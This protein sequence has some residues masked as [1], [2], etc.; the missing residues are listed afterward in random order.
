VYRADHV[1]SFLRPP[2]LLATPAK[3]PRRREIEDGA[4]LR[5]LEL[6]RE[7]GVD[8]YTDGEYRRTWFAGAWGDSVRG[9]VDAPPQPFIARGWRG[10]SSDLAMQS[11]AEVATH[12]AVGEKVRQVRRFAQDECEFLRE[13]APG[14][15][16]IT[17]TSA[18]TN[19]VYWYQP[20][21][22]AAVYPTRRELVDEMAGLLRDEVAALVDEGAAYIQL[23]SLLYSIELAD[24]ENRRRL[25]D[26]GIDPDE[27]LDEAIAGDNASLAPAMA[28]EGVT[29]GLHMCRG[30]NRS[31]WT[32]EGGYEAIAERAFSELEVDRLLLEYDTARAG[33][34]E[35]LRF[36]PDD[37]A[38]VLGLI[39]TK[40]PE[41]ESRDELLRRIEEAGRY[42]PVERLALSP[43]CGFASTAKGNLLGWDDQRRKLELVVETARE[44]WS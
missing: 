8:V 39:S 5:V 33:G 21:I 9:L 16:K 27:V 25:V 12:G 14:P 2:E 37:K 18:V 32:A 30:N 11:L 43:Q 3:D 4:I 38:V 26:C 19:A 24:P 29:V 13:H 44:I 42:V 17:L 6:Q 7:V 41:L 34:F 22:S 20:A 40:T 35:P 31:A 28:A 23:D 36:V 10:S 15:F 1:G